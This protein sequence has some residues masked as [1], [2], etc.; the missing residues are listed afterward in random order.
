ME[1]IATTARINFGTNTAYGEGAKI[2]DENK[3]R[4]KP[5][6]RLLQKHIHSKLYENT[7]IFVKNLPDEVGDEQLRNTFANFGTI[8]GA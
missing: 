4:D 7:S 6:K 3:L 5:F 2:L 1:G 8:L